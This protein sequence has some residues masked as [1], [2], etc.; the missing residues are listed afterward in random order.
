MNNLTP[1]ILIFLCALIG[2]AS[3]YESVVALEQIHRSPAEGEWCIT[4]QSRTALR[5][6]SEIFS[7]SDEDVVEL[8]DPVSY[9]RE[10]IE[11]ITGAD[12]SSPRL[13][14]AA[15]YI[16]AFTAVRSPSALVR[17]EAYQALRDICAPDAGRFDALDPNTT[18]EEWALLCER[19]LALWGDPPPQ[20][21]KS[22]LPGVK[23]IKARRGGHLKRGRMESSWNRAPMPRP[24]EEE[25]EK[26]RVASA[27]QIADARALL[28]EFS[29]VIIN[30]ASIAW[31]SLA[32]LTVHR[33][34]AEGWV[35]EHG[36]Y[37]KAVDSLIAQTFFLSTCESVF[38]TSP[39][40]SLM[41]A[42]G[43]FLFDFDDMGSLLRLRMERCYDPPLRMLILKRLVALRLAPDVLG[44]KLM[45]AVRESLDFRDP[46]VVYHAVELFQSSTAI[47]ENDPSFWRKWWSEHVVEFADG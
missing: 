20:T 38:D 28:E 34:P 1:L 22:S 43:L 46:G 13:R 42:D 5:Y 10:L 23:E 29:R 37:A 27:E 26:I 36:V 40:L 16:L 24:G 17:S 33:P 18:Q 3:P 4:S 11:E 25:E 15:V 19:W 44:G 47:K 14:G 35:D 7:G 9:C 31:D 45:S 41:A 30:S 21:I 39:T 12:L 32:L 8:D 2:C 6:V